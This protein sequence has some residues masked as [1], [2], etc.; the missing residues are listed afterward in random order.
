MRGYGFTNSTQ[1][2]AALETRSFWRWNWPLETSAMLGA[3][4]L[5]SYSFSVARKTLLQHYLKRQRLRRACKNLPSLLRL[6]L[7][8]I[9]ISQEKMQAKGV[10]I[11]GSKPIAFQAWNEESAGRRNCFPTLS[12]MQ[13]TSFITMEIANFPIFPSLLLLI[14][15]WILGN[16]TLQTAR[17]TAHGGTTTAPPFK[18]KVGRSAQ[19]L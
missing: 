4:A 2:L 1:A 10:T 11:G 12:S 18:I 9:C 7:A 14:C 5:Q 15:A 19:H 3:I 8:R 16:A 6:K 17:V 13:K